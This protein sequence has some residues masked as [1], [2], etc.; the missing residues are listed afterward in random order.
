MIIIASVAYL[1]GSIPFGYI[2]VKLFLKQD[3]RTTGSG[4][5]GATNVARSGNKGLAIATLL[6]D[7]AK[8]AVAVLWAGYKFSEMAGNW[9]LNNQVRFLASDFEFVGGPAPDLTFL[10]VA[11]L[12]A[13]IGHCFP[14]LLKF[15]GG[16]GVA[17]AIGA[18]A[19]L[20]PKA[21]LIALVCFF[22]VFAI[23][24]YVS[25]ASV[26]SAAV[27]PFLLLWLGPFSRK[28]LIF[29]LL[30]AAASLLIIFKHHGNI[31]RLIAGTEPKFGRKAIGTND[32]ME[33][34]KNL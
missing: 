32:P 23:T 17:T 19:V 11:A 7:A 22:L 14:V 2:L 28:E 18:F 16:K 25:L 27:F 24:R 12:F 20:A 5:I 9:Y 6:L 8:G 34:E 3:I 15:K 30:C 10:A 33:T 13:I 31:R 29:L 4:N 21:A 26:F 1:L